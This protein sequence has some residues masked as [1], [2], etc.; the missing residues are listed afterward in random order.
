MIPAMPKTSKDTGVISTPNERE[1]VT[2][3]ARTVSTPW[4][5]ES[6]ALGT[7]NL[8]V[9]RQKIIRFRDKLSQPMIYLFLN[10]YNIGQV[11]S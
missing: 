9:H 11:N 1:Y 8:R 2:P 4:S 10:I 5:L 3:E 7:L 6:E